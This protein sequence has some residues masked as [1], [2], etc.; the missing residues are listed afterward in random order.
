MIVYVDESDE[1]YHYGTP[2]HS[3]RY[4]WGSG[5]DP[6][7]NNKNFLSYVDDLKKQGLKETEIAKGLGISTTDL[8]AK[9][10]IAKSEVRAADSA[11]AYRLKEKGYSNVAI[12]ERMGINESSVRALLNPSLKVKND[13]L[14][15]TAKVLAESVENKKYIDVGAGVENHLGIS[16][17]KLQ[18]AV[19]VLKEKGYVVSYIPIKQLGT[20]KMTTVMVLSKPGTTWKE[21]YDNR[22]DIKLIS[23]YSEDSGRTFLGIE[24]PRSVSSKRVAVRYAED[25]GTEKDGVIELRRGVDD[26]SLGGAKYAQVRISVDGTHYLKGM[27]M[28]SDNL[29]KGVDI[30]FNTNKHKGTPMLGSKDNTVLKN[31]KDDPDNP[32]GAVVR[33]KHYIDKDGKRQLSAL[34]IVNEEGDW[35]KWSKSLSS[36]MLSKQSP[37]LAKKQLDLAYKTR[38]DE[39]D[40]IMEL[41]NP[42]VKKK[43]LE[44]FADNC[45]SAAVHLKAAA[46]PRQASHV[47][48][49]F[50]DMKENE[51]YAP[52]YR[53]GEKVVLVRYPHGGIFEIPELTVNNNQRTAKS[54]IR[55]A[56]DAVG[57]NAKVAERLSGAD[58]DGDTVLVIPNDKRSIKTAPPLKGLKDFNP[59]EAYPAYPGMKK[60]K[61]KT[62]QNEMGKVSNLITDMTIKGATEDEIA[63]AVRHSMVVIDAEKHNLNYKQ[64]YIDNGIAEL[65]K[66]Y[67]GSIRSGASTLISRASAEIRVPERKDMGWDPNTGEKIFKETGS[68]Y[69]VNGKTVKRTTKSTQ[70][71]ETNDAYSLSS[72]TVM[73][74]VY[75]K[76]A[77]DMKALANQARKSYSATKNLEYSPS[78]RKVY[79]AEVQSLKAKL[80][81]ALRNRPLERQAQILANTIVDMKKEANPDME[82]ADLKKIKGQALNEARSRVGANKK[83]IEITDTEWNAIQAGAVSNNLLEQIVNNTDLDALK[84]RATP[85]SETGLTPSK[86]ARAKLMLARGYTQA[87]VADVLGI[88]TSILKGIQG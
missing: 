35:G 3:G 44:S 37:S 83:L 24:P 15:S 46:L 87:E 63:R 27:A 45:D 29:P 33:Q 62:K 55:N 17:T 48:L 80:N 60:I 9:K 32:F 13:I 5:K 54:L 67:Q 10:A 64:S 69:T 19:S 75:A 20:D 23:D 57:I 88:S 79:D 66:K 86:E 14:S 49:P 76:Y 40:E 1:L 7:Q 26:I 8:R 22:K 82:P 85:R 28:Y 68:A 77:N 34:N 72:G 70:M 39:Y 42:V 25:G 43:L 4:P 73:E 51:I 36:Q 31:L 18:T 71:Y 50:P 38:K 84:K 74:S 16:R 65:K 30:M 12:G 41:T 56:K 58:F 81:V 78:A 53:N 47:I 21:V 52:N 61:P 6:Y 11:M 2:R 59:S